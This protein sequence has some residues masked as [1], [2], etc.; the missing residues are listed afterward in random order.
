MSVLDTLFGDPSVGRGEKAGALLNNMIPVFGILLFGWEA[1]PVL[2]LLWLDGWL[3]VWEIAVAA[4]AEASREKDPA[5]DQI[6]GLKRKL[7]WSFA[8][9]F[10]GL[11]L[12]IPSILVWAAVSSMMR[13]QYEYGLASVLA[14]GKAVLWAVGA[15]VLLRGAQA[16]PSFRR[17]SGEKMTFTLE[18]KFH[19]LIFKSFAMMMLAQWMG[20]VGQ[21][22]LIVYVVLISAFFAWTE[23]NPGRILHLLNLERGRRSKEADLVKPGKGKNRSS[24]PTRQPGDKGNESNH[25]P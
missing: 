25:E 4:A 15:N 21:F 5:L 9:L 6:Q 22:G 3:G 20:S 11:I 1:G 12:S 18:E 10:V 7:L 24:T 16:V 8:V 17:R 23:M 2:L 19:F 13:W 14:S